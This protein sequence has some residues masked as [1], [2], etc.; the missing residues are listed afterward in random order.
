MQYKDNIE[1][2]NLHPELVEVLPLVEAIYRQTLVE[3]GV[4]EMEPVMTSGAEGSPVTGPHTS[5]SR[6]YPTNC[7]S[8]YG[9]AVDIRA[10]NI[11]QTVATEVGGQIARHLRLHHPKKFRIFFENCLKPTAHFHIELERK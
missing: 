4:P 9:E 3:C 5:T 8:G 7:E 1:R 10:N 11:P 6:H 2:D